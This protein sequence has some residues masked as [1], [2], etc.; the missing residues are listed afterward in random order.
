MFTKNSI[1]NGDKTFYTYSDDFISASIIS[2]NWTTKVCWWVEFK[3]DPS[4]SVKGESTNKF[5]AELSIDAFVNVLLEEKK[6]EYDRIPKCPYCGSAMGYDMTGVNVRM[7]S[8]VESA[9]IRVG[10][11]GDL[12]IYQG[13]AK[14]GSS[15]ILEIKSFPDEVTCVDCKEKIEDKDFIQRIISSVDD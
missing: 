11:Q 15:S 8:E 13:R 10:M 3:E 12:V 1:N 9:S 6:R 4:K 5:D 7:E 14:E 2:S